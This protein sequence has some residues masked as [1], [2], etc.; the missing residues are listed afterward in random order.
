M[1]ITHILCCAAK[2]VP[3]YPDDFKYETLNALDTPN[4]DISQYTDRANAFITE[5]LKEN[6]DEHAQTSKVLVHGFAGKSRAACF[7]LA[8]LIQIRKLTL[9]ESLDKIRKVR[10][11]VAPNPGF[12]LQLKGLEK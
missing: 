10:P 4:Q 3:K 1:G 12:I 6:G 11:E 5:A 2:I 9:A 7:L 8:Y